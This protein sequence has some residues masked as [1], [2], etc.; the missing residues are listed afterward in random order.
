M[1]FSVE[2]FGSTEAIFGGFG[3]DLK[4]IFVFDAFCHLKPPGYE[5]AFQNVTLG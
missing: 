5:V 4:T 1:T 3:Q 2:A